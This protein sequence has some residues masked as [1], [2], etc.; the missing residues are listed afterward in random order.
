MEMNR[1][2]NLRKWYL[3]VAGMS[4]A[5]L[6]I[7]IVKNMVGVLYNIGYVTQLILISLVVVFSVALIVK[8]RRSNKSRLVPILFLIGALSGVVSTFTFVASFIYMMVVIFSN[9]SISFDEMYGQS[10]Q[11]ISAFNEQ[12][13][14]MLNMVLSLG[15]ITAL[16]SW[17]LLV[18]ATFLGFYNA[19][20][21]GQ[22]AAGAE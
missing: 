19:Y 20:K 1:D 13:I 6:I 21:L 4:L 11:L 7:E 8:A 16:V 3:I 14:N 22:L 15:D 9:P 12:Q 10:E 5:Y 18:S 17:V 2:L